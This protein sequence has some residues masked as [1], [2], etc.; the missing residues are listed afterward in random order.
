MEPKFDGTE[1]DSRSFFLK[2]LPFFVIA[3][4]AHHFLTAL[5][6]PLLPAI[7][8]D[9]GLS[10]TQA[11]FIP[12]AFAIAGATGQ[13]P[14]GWLADRVGPKYLIAVGTIGVALAGTLI[15]FSTSYA[16]LISSL[17]L[18]GILSGG[19]HPAA[20]PLISASV[21]PQH[22]GRALGVHLVGGNSSFFLAP[23]IA[24]A[25]L[26]LAW[27]FFHTGNSDNSDRPVYLYVPQPKKH[28]STC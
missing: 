26:E 22:R 1:P 5:P 8:D 7:R 28:P 17:L 4:A 14:S 9:F 18:M 10:Y 12:S 15:G 11:A 19:Y 25:I 21:K 6:E 3:H 23:I 27:R 24:G 13:L 20:T 2:I 16:F